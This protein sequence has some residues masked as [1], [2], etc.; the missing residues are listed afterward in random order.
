M[1]NSTSALIG[2]TTD[3]LTVF[4]GAVLFELQATHGL[5]LS[6]ALDRIIN[7]QNMAVS[8]LS[9]LEAARKNGRKDSNTI[10]DLRY[11]LEDADVPKDIREGVL[12]RLERFI[13]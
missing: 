7:Q 13:K 4:D 8:W 9:F 5:P 1:S 6:F 10:R 3:G 11:S 12:S 2:I